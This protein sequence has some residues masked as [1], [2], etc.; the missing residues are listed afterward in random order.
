MIDLGR[1]LAEGRL[2]PD[3]V[4]GWLRQRVGTG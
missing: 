4:P 2:S 1:A 3:Q